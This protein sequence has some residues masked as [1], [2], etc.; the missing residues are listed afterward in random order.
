MSLK[1]EVK[2]LPEVQAMLSNVAMRLDPAFVKAATVS[3]RLLVAELTKYPAPPPGSRYQRTMALKRGWERAAPITGGRAFEL[4]NSVPYAGLVQ[5]DGQS[6]AHR[7]RWETVSSIAK[8]MEEEVL[9]AY[10][11]ALM[12]V[13]P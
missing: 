8:R 11:D 3:R 5:G 7:G 6:G 12:E 2:Q 13:L 9:A 1:F 4:I 10:E